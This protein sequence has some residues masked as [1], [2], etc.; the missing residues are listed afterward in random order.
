[1]KKKI[2]VRSKTNLGVGV[3]RHTPPNISRKPL[4]ERSGEQLW[5]AGE[6]LRG[7]AD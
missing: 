2:T 1:M 4:V 3:R 7:H 5:G 6:L